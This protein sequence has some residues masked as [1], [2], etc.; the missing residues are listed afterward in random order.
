[1]KHL[2]NF[3][4]IRTTYSLFNFDNKPQYLWFVDKSSAWMINGCIYFHFHA[5][6]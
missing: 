3:P 6:A 1:M 4:L 2:G 5:C